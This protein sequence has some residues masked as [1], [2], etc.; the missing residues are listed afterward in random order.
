MEKIDGFGRSFFRNPKQKKNKVVQDRQTGRIQFSSIFEATETEEPDSILFSDIEERNEELVTLL[1]DIHEIGED[2]KKNPTLDV[3]KKYKKAVRDFLKI[4]INSSFA[5]EKTR[6]SGFNVLKASGHREL[7]IIKQVDEKLEKLAAGILQNQKS[8]FDILSK[9][10][11]IYGL[12][13]DLI[14]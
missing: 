6:V 7:T 1:D 2:I 14:R 3:I 13:V 8:Q 5:V 9:I 12:L 11:E 4:V 10:D